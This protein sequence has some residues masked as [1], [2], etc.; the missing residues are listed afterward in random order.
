MDILAIF[1]VQFKTLDILIRLDDLNCQLAKSYAIVSDI[2]L[3]LV[4]MLRA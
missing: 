2:Y 4:L 3:S 1:L